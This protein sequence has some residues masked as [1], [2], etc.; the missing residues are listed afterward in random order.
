MTA[1]MSASALHSRFRGLDA[2]K[3]GLLEFVPDTAPRKTCLTEG[4]RRRAGSL[5][6]LL[7]RRSAGS[8]A[9]T[10]T[11]NR[12]GTFDFQEL[13]KLLRRGNPSLTDM[14]VQALFDALDKDKDG[15]V[16]FHELSEYLHP[17]GATFEH[18]TWRKKLRT[19]FNISCPGPAEYVGND[20]AGKRNAPRPVIPSQRR[21]ADH[22]VKSLSPGPA[23]YKGNLTASAFCKNACSATSGIA[24]KGM[25][26]HSE[27]PGPG[28][29]VQNFS[30]L[31]HQEQGPR[32]TIG[33]ARRALCYE[34]NLEP[35]PGPASPC[36]HAQHKVQ[37]GNYSEVPGGMALPDLSYEKR[38]DGTLGVDEVYSSIL[39]KADPKISAAEAKQIF[40]SCDHDGDGKIKL[41]ELRDYLH[42]VTAN[43]SM[44]Y[45][46][47]G[48]HE[49]ESSERSPVRWQDVAS[50]RSPSQGSSVSSSV[51]QGFWLQLWAFVGALAN[52]LCQ[53]GQ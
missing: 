27:S 48:A 21:M 11:S 8:K 24:P 53:G 36:T 35:S 44:A 18:S 50:A 30:A 39:R 10:A 43:E 19:A 25:G 37:G 33:A 14:E 42:P 20:K 31:A 6:N 28:A 16:G 1:S 41:E 46:N 32:A 17:P 22:G 13:C 12:N 29:Y 15:N 38:Q 49:E 51:P 40:D 4:A 26:S 34:G 2:S 23:A 52:M 7:T 5:P 9:A 47:S 3:D 45:R